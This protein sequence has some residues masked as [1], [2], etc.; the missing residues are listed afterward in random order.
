[1]HT[2]GFQQLLIQGDVVQPLHAVLFC[3]DIAGGTSQIGFRDIAEL[4]G[5]GKKFSS[6]EHGEWLGLMD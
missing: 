1:V 4:L 3:A 5:L 6:D 2:V